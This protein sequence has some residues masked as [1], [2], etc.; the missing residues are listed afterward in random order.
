MSLVIFRYDKDKTGSISAADFRKLIAEYSA[1]N[2]VK[3]EAGPPKP[4]PVKTG[5]AAAPPAG[6][7]GPVPLPAP[8]ANSRQADIN[9][10]NFSFEA[11]KVFSEYDKGDG[12]VDK[13]AFENMLLSYPG[14]LGRASPAERPLIQPTA[15]SCF[16]G[17]PRSLTHY[18]ETAGVAIPASSVA[19][20]QAM[21]NSVSPLIDSYSTR[22]TRLRTMLTAK[23]LPKRENLLQLRRH[24]QVTSAEVEAVKKGIEKET[25][26][27]TQQ[28]LDRLHHV[29]S[30]RQSAI[31]HQ[32]RQKASTNFM[33]LT[34]VV[35]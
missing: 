24:L 32:V 21:G 12:R 35:G 19:A 29:E 16:D 30:L 20:H 2:A 9:A 31:K 28:I 33:Y 10:E 34:L 5:D 26:S 6:E 14:L 13:K 27:D 1:Q 11:G 22:Y 4:E 23:L 8:D 18:D 3:T 15:P 17:P 7:S 25:L